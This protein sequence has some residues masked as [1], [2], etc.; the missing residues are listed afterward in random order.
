MIQ[1]DDSKLM[2][3]FFYFPFWLNFQ[4]KIELKSI[5]YAN[6]TMGSDIQ[7]DLNIHCINFIYSACE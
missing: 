5:Y 2:I 4:A 3:C 1:G 7:G 6:G